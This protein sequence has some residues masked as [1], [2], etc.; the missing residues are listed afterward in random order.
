[1]FDSTVW[2]SRQL[3]LGHAF[4]PNT[5]ILVPGTGMGP[6]SRIANLQQQYFHT[7]LRIKR[8]RSNSTPQHLY[9]PSG[10]PDQGLV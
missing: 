8:L 6:G 10:Q 5:R 2:Q 7:I 3:P 1:M 4:N 9:G